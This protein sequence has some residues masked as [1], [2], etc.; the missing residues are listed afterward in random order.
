MA[1][2]K[3]C[4]QYIDIKIIELPVTFRRANGSEMPAD[5]RTTRLVPMLVKISRKLTEN[6]MLKS[7]GLWC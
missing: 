6:S 2:G 4:D 7:L 1:M 3:L 5:C